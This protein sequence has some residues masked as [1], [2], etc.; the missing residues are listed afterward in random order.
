MKH[1]EE[2]TVLI[3][4]GGRGIGFACA[5]YFLEQGAF[6]TIAD[7]H[8]DRVEKALQQLSSFND[9]LTG[10]VDTVATPQ[11]A[12]RIVDEATERFGFIDAL[13]NNASITRDN[14]LVNLSE[15]DFDEVIDTNLKGAFYCI[16]AAVPGMIERGGGRIINMIAASGLAGNPGQSNYASAK[17]GLLALTLTLSAELKK[18]NISVNAVIPAA[19]TEMSETIPQEVLLKIVGEKQLSM[20]KARTPSQVAPLIGFLASDEAG[21][22]TGQCLSIAGKQLS[23]WEYSKPC[24]EVES[25][26]EQWSFE[27]FAKFVQSSHGSLWQT[28]VSP[29][30]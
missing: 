3:T 17:G 15:K 25:V 5:R 19:W 18:K 12:R 13:V 11:G 23:V 1:L 7:I 28:P 22:I 6:V 16:K 9:R 2:K 24:I 29:F 20:M 4:G 26:N 10:I 27:E 14:L 8:P 21:N 30:L